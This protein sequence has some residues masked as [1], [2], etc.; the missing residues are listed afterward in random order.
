MK[1]TQTSEMDEL[2]KEK[3]KFAYLSKYHDLKIQ[4]IKALQNLEQVE[5]EILKIHAHIERLG[6]S[7]LIEPV[8]GD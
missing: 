3:Q 7:Q 8:R 5:A 4:K 1:Q 2:E 6:A